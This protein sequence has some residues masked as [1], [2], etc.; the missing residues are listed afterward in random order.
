MTSRNIKGGSGH[1]KKLSKSPPVIICHTETHDRGNIYD[2]LLGVPKNAGVLPYGF[3]DTGTKIFVYYK[4]PVKGIKTIVRAKGPPYEDPKK[5]PEWSDEWPIEDYRH[6]INTE[7]IARYKIPVNYQ[8]LVRMGVRRRDTNTLFCTG[9]LR[10]TVVPIREE[11]GASIESKL[12]EKNRSFP[13][14]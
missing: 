13:P 5:V 12:I 7:P 4:Y 11:D 2:R 10:S 6:R 14:A 1:M 8:E 3:V 9:H